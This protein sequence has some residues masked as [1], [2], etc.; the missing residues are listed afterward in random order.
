[1]SLVNHK[2][3]SVKVKEISECMTVCLQ[4]ENQ[5]NVCKSF[6]IELRNDGGLRTCEIND[7]SKEQDPEAFECRNRFLYYGKIQSA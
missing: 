1:M 5:G 4:W 6:N 7:Q 3:L 2:S